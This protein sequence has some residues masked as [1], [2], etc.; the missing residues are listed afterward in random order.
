MKKCIDCKLEKSNEEFPYDKSRNRHLSV[1][2]PCTSPRTKKYKSQNPQKWKDYSKNNHLKNKKIIN[3][4]KSPGCKKCG[5]SRVWVL[6]AHHVNPSE[7]KLAIGE[8]P[9]GS[10][11]LKE[12][13]KK[14]IPLCSNCHKD[15]HY[16]EKKTG[17]SIEEYVH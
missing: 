14:C 16:Q 1:C 17:V 3:E 11:K 12:E 15:F 4:W 9:H 13:L 2:K 6:D 8:G 10:K 7:K 5:E